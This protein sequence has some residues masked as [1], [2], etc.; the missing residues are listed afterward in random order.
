MADVQISLLMAASK[1]DQTDQLGVKA[2]PISEPPFATWQ[3]VVT[4]VVLD[5][6][7]ETFGLGS[8]VSLEELRQVPFPKPL[9]SPQAIR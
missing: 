5:Q 3:A 9:H 6:G 1:P 8:V 7:Q 4:A 2:Q